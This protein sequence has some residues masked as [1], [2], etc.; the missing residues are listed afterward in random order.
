MKNDGH[1]KFG[2]CDIVRD[3]DDETLSVVT[4]KSGAKVVDSLKEEAGD[5]NL[6][7]TH[8]KEEDSK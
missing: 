6:H 3:Q 4:E 2:N 8:V 5:R 1:I 7:P